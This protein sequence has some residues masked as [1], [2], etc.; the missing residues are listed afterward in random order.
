MRQRGR[1][2][3]SSMPAVA[4]NKVH[5]KIYFI[6]IFFLLFFYQSFDHPYGRQQQSP[7]DR[8]Q[9]KQ[10]YNSGGPDSGAD[11]EGEDDDRERQLSD[12]Y[13]RIQLVD[14][15]NSMPP[16]GQVKNTAVSSSVSQLQSYFYSGV[17]LEY[18][19]N[20]RGL[21]VGKSLDIRNQTEKSS[22]L[23]FHMKTLIRL[24][25]ELEI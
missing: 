18:V 23:R 16:V 14:H 8:Y 4:H 19:Y 24:I 20:A 6:K 3:R 12:R 10:Y 15:C 13:S 2:R 21:L 17:F 11:G 25:G 1:P 9:S 5:L 22:V 7:P